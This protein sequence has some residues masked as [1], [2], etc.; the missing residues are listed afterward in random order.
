MSGLGFELP[1]GLVEIDLLRAESK[2]LSTAKRDQFHAQGGSIESDGRVYI[3]DRQNQVVEMIDSES[4]NSV[5]RRRWPM[6]VDLTISVNL[7]RTV[8]LGY[9][10]ASP[11]DKLRAGPAG[12]LRFSRCSTS[13]AKSFV[14][15]RCSN[16]A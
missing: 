1:S 12:L 3:G 7:P 13:T 5:T 4:H 9:F 15:S 8:V 14:S 6:T 11:F 10:H 2:C 16:F